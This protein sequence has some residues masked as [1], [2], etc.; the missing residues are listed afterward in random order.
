MK[1][2]KIHGLFLAAAMLFF[3]IIQ[4]HIAAADAAP[5]LSAVADVADATKGGYINVSVNLSGNPSIST[6]GIALNYDSGAL[7]YDSVSWNGAF[8][9]NDICMTSDTGGAVNLSVVCENS[10]SADGTIA[11]VRFRANS[12]E[13]SIPV[14]LSLRDIADEDLQAIADCKVSSR[15]HTPA[16]VDKADGGQNSNEPKE[17][18]ADDANKTAVS[19][20]TDSE[21]AASANQSTPEQKAPASVGGNANPDQNY[22]T[23]AVGGNANPD[24]NYKTGA[25]LGNDAFLVI[26]VVCGILALALLI[27]KHKEAKS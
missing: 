5:S 11:T 1:N 25:G 22:K 15:V 10:Y 21:N 16:K 18:A 17:E 2:K 6:L 27:H 12:D 4:I 23:G 19:S 13:P 9:E 14:K 26:S 20:K 3:C 7:S 8:S 24:Q